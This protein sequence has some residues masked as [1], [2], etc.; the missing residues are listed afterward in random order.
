MDEYLTELALERFPQNRPLWECHLIMYTT[1]NATST[2]VLKFH[3]SLGDGYSL[4]GI[5]FS[6]MRRVDN[7]SLPLTFPSRKAHDY[8][9][10]KSTNR[11]SSSNNNNNNIKATSATGSFWRL[12]FQMLSSLIDTISNFTWSISSS[13]FFEDDQTPIR[14][15][16]ELL[17]FHPS[18]L[19]NLT[20]PLDRIKSVKNQL[21]AV[22]SFFYP[23]IYI[24]MIIS[25]DS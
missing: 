4:M 11:R 2:L 23:Y 24:Y 9:S 8:Y 14:S 18:I 15:G 3:H 17:E 6:L 22:S 25:I 1:S 16:R 10:S 7:P 13:T 12:P 21:G 20:F 19:T 5:I